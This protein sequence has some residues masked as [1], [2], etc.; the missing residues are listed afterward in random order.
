MKAL[1]WFPT[2]RL[3]LVLVLWFVVTLLIVGWGYTSAQLARASARGVYDS[4][5]EG[6]RSRLEERYVGIER[7]DILYAGTNSFDGSRPQVWYVIAEV[8]AR[9]RADGSSLGENGCDAPGSFFLQTEEGWVWVPEGA[10]P[11]I[12]G[13][14]MDMFGMA[15][16]G[17]ST[18]S[19]D[20]DPAQP[21]KFC[22]GYLPGSEGE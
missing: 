14:W 12:V 11:Q 21:A 15:G 3:V 16:P 8:R 6:I 13:F 18:P 22:T 10:F 20:W 17:Q 19:T 4:A 5:E 9:S 1:S 2:L 7:I